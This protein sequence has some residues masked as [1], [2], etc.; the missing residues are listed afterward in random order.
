MAA[1]PANRTFPALNTE[2]AKFH[3]IVASESPDVDPGAS[4]PPRVGQPEIPRRRPSLELPTTSAITLPVM[5]LPFPLPLAVFGPVDWFVL[6]G[7]LAAMLAIGL[8]A[9]WRESRAKS[10]TKEFFLG[11]RSMPT[12]ALAISIVRSSLSV[13]TFTGVPDSAY[14][15]NISYLVLNLGNFIAAFLVAWLFVP[16]LYRAGT[17]TVHGY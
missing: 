4:V 5:P 6:G 2:T 10:G 8:V 16:P 13:A 12:W 15:G 3:R 1:R 7:Y 11:G 14:Y 17:V 9:A